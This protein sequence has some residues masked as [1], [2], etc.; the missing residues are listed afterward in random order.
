[1]G[2]DLW[3]YDDAVKRVRRFASRWK[4]MTI[5]L[6]GE[7]H[8]ARVALSKTGRPESGANAPVRTWAGFCRDIGID[9]AT[10]NRW[11]SRFDPV[12]KRLIDRPERPR[13]AREVDPEEAEFIVDHDED[14]GNYLDGLKQ[15]VG[16]LPKSLPDPADWP[17]EEFDRAQK[18]VRAL[19]KRL[20]PW[21]VVVQESAGAR[22]SGRGCAEVDG[23]AYSR[24]PMLQTPREQSVSVAKLE[25]PLYRRVTPTL[26]ITVPDIKPVTPRAPGWFGAQERL[27]ITVPDIKA[28]V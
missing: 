19:V 14:V 21:G 13:Q 16:A 5:E 1:M 25:V 11:L 8:S 4:D 9:K 6:A 26:D 2:N 10:A 23:A 17:P 15:A 24:H 27:D 22:V 12:A 28:T 20:A 3:S 7:L 18:F